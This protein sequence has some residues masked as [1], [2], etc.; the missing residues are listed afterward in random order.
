VQPKAA[1]RL[2][3]LLLAVALALAV[4]LGTL[5][6]TAPWEDG[7]KG[8]NGGAYIAR[9]LQS[10][11]QFG[12]AV[13][14]GAL[15]QGLDPC[16]PH[17]P[18]I[19]PNHPATTTLLYLPAAALFGAGEATVRVMALLL[20]LPSIAAVWWLARR[21]LGPPAAGVCALLF[22]SAPMAAYY[23]PM[24]AADGLL[25]GCFPLVA[26][27]FLAHAEQ[28]T[29]ARAVRLAAAVGFA[30]LLDWS[31]AFMAPMLLALLPLVPDRRRALASLLRL[32][33]VAVVAVALLFA[34]SAFTLGGL[35]AAV[36]Q[37]RELV[38][39]TQHISPGWGELLAGE[40]RD[41]RAWFGVP[42][43]VL[44]ALGALTA[45]LARRDVHLRRALVAAAA[46][47]LPGLLNVLVF[48]AHAVRH[49]FW[50]MFATP[51]LALAAAVPLAAA[52]RASSQARAPGR[53]RAAVAAALLGLACTLTACWGVLDTASA[54]KRNATTFHR[55]VGR[56][57]DRWFGPDAVVITSVQLSLVDLYAQATVL[58]PVT[59]P[60]LARELAAR[61]APPAF[62][63][64]L[65][66]LLPWRERNSELA[67]ALGRMAVPET[68]PR[69][70]VYRVRP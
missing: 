51:G 50:S 32:A 28:P 54:T 61:Y 35:A 58:G 57:L 69:A 39:F 36:A 9:F 53:R 23:G 33:A 40:S 22:A 27:L 59:E 29:R 26:A 6:L 16:A 5:D 44:G 31:A 52:L 19:Y 25:L 41:A 13:T 10:H 15:V 3:R 70:V 34:H 66:F 4:A 67:E 2:D 8:T 42:L 56:R 1:L 48:R 37:W 45:L 38:R 63:G 14:R 47:A 68:L 30:C 11:L 21:L 60:Q 49:D 43:L 12:L 55:D 65:V 64:P 24:A 7:F 46:V 17:A 18:V 62:T 20:Y